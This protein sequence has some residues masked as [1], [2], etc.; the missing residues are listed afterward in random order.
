MLPS[1]SAPSLSHTMTQRRPSAWMSPSIVPPTTL[2]AVSS[3]RF[4]HES[5]TS[6]TVTL[7][8]TVPVIAHLDV[9]DDRTGDLL[10]EP[11]AAVERLGLDGV[12]ERP[13]GS[14]DQDEHGRTRDQRKP[15]NA[16]VSIALENHD[17]GFEHRT[18][19][20]EHAAEQQPSNEGTERSEDPEVEHHERRPHRLRVGRNGH[21]RGQRS[22]SDP[23]IERVGSRQRQ[24]RHRERADDE[25]RRRS[26][27]QTRAEPGP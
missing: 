20:A 9:A 18:S 5:E 6:L 19:R 26:E 11:R 4:V 8:F 16:L 12:R 3:V 14:C 21:P 25:P 13:E 7:P 1:T 15:S 2:M 27:H 10:P 23:S 24:Q 22:N 17:R